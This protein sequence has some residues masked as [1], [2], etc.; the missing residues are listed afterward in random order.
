MIVKIFGKNGVGWEIGNKKLLQI[1]LKR[2]QTKNV[3]KTKEEN[4][5]TLST[6]KMQK[7]FEIWHFLQNWT[8]KLAETWQQ[9]VQG[10]PAINPQKNK[11]FFINYPFNKNI[12]L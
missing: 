11:Y 10:N 3:E 4:T 12:Y 7:K 1:N 6:I 9:C 5:K 2:N 8:G